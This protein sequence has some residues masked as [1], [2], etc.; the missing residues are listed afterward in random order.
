M[1]QIIRKFFASI[2]QKL[3][4]ARM[5][6][7]IYFRI[8]PHMNQEADHGYSFDSK[9]EM[10]RAHIRG[11]LQTSLDVD[12]IERAAARMPE[13]YGD[14]FRYIVYRDLGRRMER[15]ME[16]AERRIQPE[17]CDPHDI[18]TSALQ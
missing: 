17:T 16:L 10:V 11:R 15:Y 9:D 12:L 7:E 4:E 2:R 3:F 6:R 8:F 14:A 5:E 1:K 13:A 18:A